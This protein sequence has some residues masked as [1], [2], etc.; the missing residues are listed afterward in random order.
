MRHFLLT[1]CSKI[2]IVCYQGFKVDNLLTN[3]VFPIQFQVVNV[4]HQ[5][6]KDASCLL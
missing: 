3:V 6:I 5:L 1:D 4:M 2:V